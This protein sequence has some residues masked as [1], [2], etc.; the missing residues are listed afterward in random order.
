[1]ATTPIPHP[2]S[3]A[4]DAVDAILSLL[5]ADPD[6]TLAA[7]VDHLPGDG[8]L[9]YSVEDGHPGPSGAEALAAR[10]TILLAD[11]PGSRVALLSVR[12]VEGATVAEADL[13]AWRRLVRA[14]GRSPFT[15][16]DWFIVTDDAVLSL[17]ELAGP[18]ARWDG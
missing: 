17:A 2:I 12:E 5:D 16:L 3:C 15:L 11:A 14:H 4:L 7:I 6:T 10:L 8:Q 13:A 1:M 9:V 18:R